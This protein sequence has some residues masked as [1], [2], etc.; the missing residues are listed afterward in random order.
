[1]RA[2][3]R[4]SGLQRLARFALA[5]AAEHGIDAQTAPLTTDD[6]LDDVQDVISREAFLRRYAGC[7]YNG[8]IACIKAGCLRRE[9]NKPPALDVDQA[10]PG[11]VVRLLLM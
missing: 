1:V 5:M 10:C 4:G 9:R 6:A 7:S 2:C 11:G 8:P 3:E